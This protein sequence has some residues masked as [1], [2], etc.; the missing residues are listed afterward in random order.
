M[1]FGQYTMYN[2]IMC[3]VFDVDKKN[4]IVKLKSN[5]NIKFVNRNDVEEIYYI[6]TNCF[7]KGYEFQVLSEKDDKILIYTNNNEVGAKLKMEFIERSEYQKWIKKNEVE[8][9]FEKKT[10]L[11]L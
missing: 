5:D 4:K 1:L 8:S 11:D 3:K 6:N 9:I 2:G 7:Y 10:I